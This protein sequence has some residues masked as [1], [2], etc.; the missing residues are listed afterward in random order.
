[1]AAAIGHEIRNPLTAVRGYLQF[2][3]SKKETAVFS[4]QLQTMIEEIDRANAIISEFLSLAKNKA[5]ELKYNNLNDII[6]VLKPL[7]QAEAFRI[8]HDLQVH[9]GDIPLYSYG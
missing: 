6:S 7:L 1:M 8:G 4:E 2:F 9:L 3:Q 5:V